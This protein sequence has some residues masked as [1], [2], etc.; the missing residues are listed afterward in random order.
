MKNKIKDIDIETDY[1]FLLQVSKSKLKEWG[2]LE[3]YICRRGGDKFNTDG[4]DFITIFQAK[5]IG[6]IKSG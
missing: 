1:S 3:E 5:L 6:L 4:Y 2:V